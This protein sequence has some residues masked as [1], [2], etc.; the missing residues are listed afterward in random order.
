M[1]P[2]LSKTEIYLLEYLSS[3]RGSLD[4]IDQTTTMEGLSIKM[5]S[6][7]IE[8]ADYI[9]HLVSLNFIEPEESYRTKLTYYKI[10]TFGK[11]YLEHKKNNVKEKI[12]W[13]VAVPIGVSV[14]T[15]IILRI[16]LG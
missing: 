6:S 10:T 2:Q 12:V 14:A 16:I 15:S 13:S 8:I 7:S 5:N 1:E 9:N 11:T 4:S 3:Y